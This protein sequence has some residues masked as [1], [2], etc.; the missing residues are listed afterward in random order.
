M[1][2][3]G[4]QWGHN[5]GTKGTQRGH[6]RAQ[7]VH[8]R[9]QRGHNRAQWGH[10]RG[11]KGAQPGTKGTQ[12]DTKASKPCEPRKSSSRMGVLG[13]RFLYIKV[14]P[15]SMG[16]PSMGILGFVGLTSCQTTSDNHVSFTLCH[17]LKYMSIVILH[18]YEI[19]FV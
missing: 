10:N 2:K 19:Y 8:N 18:L 6:N 13:E 4:A 9:A 3:K 7:R 1:M 16:V 17:A 15:S 11:T 12:W 5:R 14:P